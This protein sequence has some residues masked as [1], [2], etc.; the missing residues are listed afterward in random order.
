M[1][2]MGRKSSEWLSTTCSRYGLPS[3]M[4][5]MMPLPVTGDASQRPAGRWDQNDVGD[6]ACDNKGKSEDCRAMSVDM[7]NRCIAI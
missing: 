7:S 4:A 5:P 6:C 3:T 1:G 2:L